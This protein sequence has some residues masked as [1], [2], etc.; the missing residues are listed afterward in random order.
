MTEQIHTTTIPLRWTD[1]D[2]FGH[3]NN[4]KYLEFS[5]DARVAYLKDNF[6]GIDF[7]VFVRRLEV[8]LRA[9]VEP[10]SPQ[11]TVTSQVFEMGNT[12]FT[13]RQEIKDHQDTVAAVVDTVLVAIDPK[14]LRPRPL[15]D[16]E[17]QLMGG[18]ETK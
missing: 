16:E 1:F 17:R 9:P 8:D 15:T 3:V 6:G 18:G 14:T 11:V 7:K 10:T 2:L 12:S 13:T 4:S 5:Q